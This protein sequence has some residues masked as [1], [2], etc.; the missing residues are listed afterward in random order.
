MQ[1]FV[2]TF[3]N[4]PGPQQVELKVKIQIPGS[5]F[6]GDGF[7]VGKKYE[8]VAAEYH[9]NHQFDKTGSKSKFCAKAIRALCAEDASDDATHKGYWIELVAWNRYRNDTFKDRRDDEA[10]YIVDSPAK[11]PAAKASDTKEP[12]KNSIKSHY[13]LVGKEAH[14]GTSKDGSSF[15]AV[16]FSYDCK[17]CGNKKH[18]GKP[19]KQIGTSTGDLLKHMKKCD[20]GIYTACRLVGANSKLVKVLV[21]EKKTD[22]PA[23]LAFRVGKRGWPLLTGRGLVACAQG[24]DGKLVELYSFK[25]LL[26]RHVQF[27]L[28]CVLEFEPFSKTESKGLL[29]YLR[30]FDPH[31]ATPHRNTAKK[32]LYV[33]KSLMERTLAKVVK[34]HAEVLG[35]P[36]SGATADVWSMPSCRDSFM[37]TRLS[38][39][40]D[41]DMLAGLLELPSCH[42]AR[43]ARPYSA[44][45]A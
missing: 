9:A 41:G 36:H 18:G 23:P 28:W 39:V 15:A 11:T 13:E 16:A 14:K 35:D 37:A 27:V 31:A 1:A 24:S 26:P 33:I 38:M 3:T 4:Y 7:T 32:I 29:E 45:I 42:G 8:C 34:K 17:V 19:I 22:C 44:S 21:V 25:Q 5:A 2:D 20:Q 30:G 10:K 6:Q 40:L 12:D 43:R